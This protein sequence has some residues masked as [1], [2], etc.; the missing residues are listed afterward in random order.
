MLIVFN[1]YNCYCLYAKQLLTCYM[2]HVVYPLHILLFF[3][4]A[5]QRFKLGMPGSGETLVYNGYT[6]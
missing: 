5:Y 6:T 2:Y 3:P 1:I 4:K